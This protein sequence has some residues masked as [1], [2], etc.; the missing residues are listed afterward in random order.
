MFVISDSIRWY[1]EDVKKSFA[2]SAASRKTIFDP[3]SSAA[4]AV[5]VSVWLDGRSS[6]YLQEMNTHIDITNNETTMPT[7]FLRFIVFN[8]IWFI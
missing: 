5:E 6:S 2:T 7:K 3:S 8:F 4:I 1:V